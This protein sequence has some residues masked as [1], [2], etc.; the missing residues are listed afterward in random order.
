MP[1]KNKRKKKSKPR[2]AQTVAAVPVPTPHRPQLPVHVG[3]ND[4][5][6]SFDE[7]AEEF[8]K[9][10]LSWSINGPKN[11]G[12]AAVVSTFAPNKD[13]AFHLACE[14]GDTTVVTSMLKS[15]SGNPN[16]RSEDGST[17]LLIASKRGHQEV[18]LL[19]IESGRAPLD[20]KWVGNTSCTP[21][22]LWCE[23]GSTR[24]VR[25]LLE[26]GASPHLADEFG[27]TP[28]YAAAEYN[29]LE[30]L[31][32]L[33]ATQADLNMKRIDGSTAVIVSA[34]K[35]HVA[36]LESLYANGGDLNARLQDG[37]TCLS[38]AAQ[39]HQT[40]IV[41]SLL[42]FGCV[43]NVVNDTMCSPLWI[44]ASR[45]HEDLVHVLLQACP[46][47][48]FV[49]DT[50]NCMNAMEIAFCTENMDIIAVII[51]SLPFAICD[52][53]T[54]IKCIIENVQFLTGNGGTRKKSLAHLL[55]LEHL[56]ID[57]SED[58]WPVQMAAN[59]YFTLGK[60]ANSKSAR[61][62]GNEFY[63]K[64]KYSHAIEA[65]EQAMVMDRWCP[66]APS[67][68]SEAALQLSDFKRAL[69]F[70]LRARG[71]DPTHKKSWFRYVKSL[72]GLNRA[73]EAFVW[74]ADFAK[75]GAIDQGEQVCLFEAVSK[76]SPFCYEFLPGLIVQRCD[77]TK[78]KQQY[79]IITTKAIPSQHVLSKEIAVVDWTCKDV[80]D[81]SRTTEF[82]DRFVPEEFE[83][84]RGVFPRDFSEIPFSTVKS[85]GAL[86]EKLRTL[87]PTETVKERREWI[88]ALAC[89]KLSAFDNGIHHF[90]S[91]YNHSC[92]PNCEVRSIHNLEIVASR[93]IAAGEELCISYFDADF[94]AY[95]VEP[96]R[97]HLERGWGSPCLCG[98]CVEE[99]RQPNR[100]TCDQVHEFDQAMTSHAESNGF[101]YPPFLPSG[102]LFD[103][104]EEVSWKRS[105]VVQVEYSWLARETLSIAMA[106]VF[107]GQSVLQEQFFAVEEMVR[108]LKKLQDKG[109][110]V[111]LTLHH[112][113]MLTYLPMES[114]AMLGIYQT[115]KHFVDGLV[116]SHTVGDVDGFRTRSQLLR[117]QTELERFVRILGQSSGDTD[118]WVIN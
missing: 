24:V 54:V 55:G 103:D 3:E 101:R 46:G 51:A 47:M 65:Y 44:A 22:I 57:I 37:S 107:A 78:E 58:A 31:P 66:F 64:K 27:T 85:L 102:A 18:C 13:K 15:R 105:L 109:A 42:N 72:G 112:E 74:I 29:R 43:A 53:S 19:L 38:L 88:R 2:K 40:I 82:I 8:L 117:K 76:V 90:A 10:V 77:G 16:M 114:A 83:K 26:K 50:A 23:H 94:L 108:N 79:R 4:A 116:A 91:F 61:E 1:R 5:P 34:E 118:A 87:K 11:I 75:D 69:E 89:A 68:A 111:C 100:A 113:R 12:E 28:V 17:P 35:G 80:W 62:A 59:N 110:L 56:P 71:I 52:V 41:K 49:E 14:V 92:E 21:L 99:V 63:S 20:C 106:A 115:M 9:Q 96:R 6:S 7:G 86:Q 95:P 93:D 73:S 48:L 36:V 25:A 98:R 81:E 60:Y 39:N 97:S 33:Y 30:I 104:W 45:G 32:L 84:I 70:S 67:N